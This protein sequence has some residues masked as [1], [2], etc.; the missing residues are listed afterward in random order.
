MPMFAAAADEESLVVQC[1]PIRYT[2]P[3]IRKH[4]V[5]RI[6]WEWHYLFLSMDWAHAY[7]YSFSHEFCWSFF[8]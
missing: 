1:E 3:D 5:V 4:H 6:C 2:A 8:N 7:H